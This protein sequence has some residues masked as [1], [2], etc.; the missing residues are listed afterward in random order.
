MPIR[1]MFPEALFSEMP[2]LGNPKAAPASIKFRGESG[3]I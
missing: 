1:R 3:A 2:V